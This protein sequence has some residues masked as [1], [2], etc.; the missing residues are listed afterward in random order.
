MLLLLWAGSG[1][2]SVAHTAVLIII[3]IFYNECSVYKELI[4]TE[5]RFFF[6]G[7]VDVRLTWSL[8]P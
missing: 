8:T 6:A 5:I 3:I 4:N 2:N 1:S 7:A